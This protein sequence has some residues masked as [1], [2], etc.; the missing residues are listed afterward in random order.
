MRTMIFASACLVVAALAGLPAQESGDGAGPLCLIFTVEQDEVV[1][2]V[3]G[4]K[5]RLELN[6]EPMPERR[7]T[8]RGKWILIK[9]ARGVPVASVTYSKEGGN[10]QILVPKRKAALGITMGTPGPSLAAHL[11]L[12]RERVVILDAIK[13]GSAAAEAG[14]EKYD[15]VT[16]VDGK[17]PAT[18]QRVQEAVTKKKPGDR[19][20]LRVVRKGKPCEVEVVLGA[21]LEAGLDAGNRI[22]A[23]EIVTYWDPGKPSS[24]GG[25]KLVPGELTFSEPVVNLS[26]QEPVKF[27]ELG[28]LSMA[29]VAPAV[30][31]QSDRLKRLES[32]L[33]RIEAR[34]KEILERLGKRKL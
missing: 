8:I 15:V 23:D 19:I 32:R 10:V 25:L 7:Y 16:H 21:E 5:P 22:R 17:A 30:P 34:L 6:G 4:G 11:G 31:D 33:E 12:D 26:K 3:R 14:L 18:Q 2:D 28:K 9:D 13:P 20:R 29:T 24:G 27:F 1:V